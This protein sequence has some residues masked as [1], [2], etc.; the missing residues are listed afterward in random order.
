M[1]L[2]LSCTTNKLKNN[3]SFV[4]QLLYLMLMDVACKLAFCFSTIC[5]LLLLCTF[6]LNK[7]E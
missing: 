2:M 6:F 1:N 3:F 4:H 5:K 7:I